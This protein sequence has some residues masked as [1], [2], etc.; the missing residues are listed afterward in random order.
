VSAARNQ[1]TDPDGP[2]GR[3]ATWVSDVVLEQAPASVR[4]RA[5]HLLLDGLG[6]ALVGAQLP[7]SRTAVDAVL[8][9]E[10][11][12]DT[13]VVGWGM[14]TGPAAA[15]LLNGT[16]IQG[17]ELDDFHPRAP[18]HSN[19]LLIPAL[20]AA[21]HL[22]PSVTCERFLGALI[23]GYETGPRVGLALHGGEMLT[24][25]WHSGS[26]FGTIS[27][28]AAVANLLEL[29]PGATEDALG[30]GAT[31]SHGLMA[32]QF[33][34]MSK[35]MHHGLASRN[36][37]YAAMLA[38][39][40]YTGI[41]QVFEVPYGGF[42]SVFGEGHDPDPSQIESELGERWETERI[43]VKPYAAMGGLHAAIDAVADVRGRRPLRANEL[44]RID[45]ELSAA[46]YHHGWWAPERPL[47]P[48]GAQMNIAYV[49]AAAILDGEVLA[50]QFS[51][52]RLDSDDIWELIPRIAARHNP[53]FDHRAEDRG[54]TVLTVRFTD[55]ETLESRQQAARSILIP[56]T[57]EEIAAKYRQLTRGVI[58]PER[59]RRLEELALSIDRQGDLRSLQSL[60]APA[61]S[62]PL[63]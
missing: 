14:G 39:G 3:L 53:E 20:L 21:A 12:G 31:Q 9:F 62:S 60:L 2:T 10:A 16:F 48:T 63:D 22:N 28:A 23:A 61:V 52:A 6:C 25:G 40:G 1:P 36:G 11:P 13:P 56:P 18:L 19:S 38:R 43:A 33:G 47:T 57:N 7:W 34:A 58:D 17:F 42:L 4:D 41:K 35:R 27:T 59:Q 15:T 54:K 44:A 32:A 24:R 55:G 49:L 37:L 30:L 5:K 26:V 29:D 50:A 46:V 45:V 8:A 51:A